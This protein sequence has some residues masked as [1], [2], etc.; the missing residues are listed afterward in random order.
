MF[1]SKNIIN[2]VLLA[3]I[4]V[5]SIAY[6]AIANNVS[7]AFEYDEQANIYQSKI[8][9]IEKLSNL[10]AEKNMSLFDEKETVYITV[11]D[12]VND[13]LLEADDNNGSVKDPTSEVKTL[14]DVKIR[15]TNKNGKVTVKVLT[16]QN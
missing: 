14:N 10:Y 13:N 4:I 5:F 8:A 15:L 1:K 3:V 6:F 2:Y 11:Q 7:H 12:L 9:L 16:D